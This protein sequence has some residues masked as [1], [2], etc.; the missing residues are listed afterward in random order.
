MLAAMCFYTLEVIFL[1]KNTDNRMTYIGVVVLERTIIS[2]NHIMKLYHAAFIN[3]Q[4]KITTIIS[5]N[6]CKEYN[7]PFTKYKLLKYSVIW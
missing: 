3:I 2:R 1:R 6:K 7:F 5:M 4:P